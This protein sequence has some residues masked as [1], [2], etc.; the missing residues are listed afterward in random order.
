MRCASAVPRNSATP[1]AASSSA[2]RASL[3]AITGEDFGMDA[4]FWRRWWD[5]AGAA[6]VVPTNEELAKKKAVIESRISA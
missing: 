6:F 3:Y 4:A 2:A 1:A 5:R